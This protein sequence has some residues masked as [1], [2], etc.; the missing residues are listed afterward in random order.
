M[1]LIFCFRLIR[2]NL[3]VRYELIGILNALFNACA[4]RSIVVFPLSTLLLVDT[5]NVCGTNC[6]DCWKLSEFLKK[7]KIYGCDHDNTMDVKSMHNTIVTITL[8]YKIFNEY[9]TR[10]SFNNKTE[11]NACCSS[12]AVSLQMCF[13][14]CVVF[15]VQPHI[16]SD[17]NE[18]NA[19]QIACKSWTIGQYIIS[20]IC[21]RFFVCLS[22]FTTIFLNDHEQRP[23]QTLKNIQISYG[24]SIQR[25][26]VSMR[27]MIFAAASW[28]RNIPLAL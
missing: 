21:M 2:Q 22:T 20:K 27:I 14:G 16:K 12:A 6:R 7:K 24:T 25:A 10:A 28:P 5:P 15:V 18:K 1:R 19:T 8:Y 17:N 4:L 9:A 3:S 13:F 23:S 26:L 11:L